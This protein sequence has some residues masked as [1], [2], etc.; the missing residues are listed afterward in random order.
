VIPGI[1]S[2]GASEH[3][4]AAASRHADGETRRR[5]LF[6]RLLEDYPHQPAT[7]YWRSIEVAALAEA[8]LPEGRGA[9]FG[10][11]DGVVTDVLLEERALAWRLTGIDHDVLETM[12]G[13]E[14]DAYGSGVVGSGYSLPLQDGSVDFIFA[15]SV[16]EHIPELERVLGECFRS[17]KGGGVLIATVP[18]SDLH[19]CFRGPSRIE[20]A[21][22]I[23]RPRY[24]ANFDR[25]AQHVNYWDDDT[26]RRR[27]AEAGF[28]DVT[29]L[30]FFE[31]RE[32]HLFESL[33]RMT[34]GALDLLTRGRYLPIELQRRIGIRRRH[35]WLKMINPMWTGASRVLM[36]AR[37]GDGGG[38]HACRIITARRG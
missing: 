19:A 28:D 17:L 4:S 27:L 14:R 31:E 26:W 1:A 7:A 21:V 22:G 36:R 5:R 3:G 9:D 10:F 32:F 35:G 18:S 8:E 11:G 6:R 12:L 23:D 30:P 38:R 24:L 2:T 25:R 16:L 20:R 13:V 37:R 29:I 33:V 34:S 15:N